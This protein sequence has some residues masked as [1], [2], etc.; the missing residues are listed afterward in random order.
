ML[1]RQQ[2]AIVRKIAKIQEQSFLRIIEEEKLKSLLLEML[3]EGYDVSLSD[4]EAEASKNL[5]LWDQ[6]K[7]NPDGFLNILDELNLGMVRHT[8]VNEFKSNNPNIGTLHRKLTLFEE[9]NQNPN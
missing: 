7:D 6:V 9:I 5:M 1:S 4:L 3:D 2:K 8:L